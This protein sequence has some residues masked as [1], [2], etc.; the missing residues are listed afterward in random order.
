MARREPSESEESKSNDEVSSEDDQ[1]EKTD[2][3]GG[4]YE[5]KE[6]AVMPDYERQRLERMAANRAR[7]EALGL[8]TLASSLMSPA[9]QRSKSAQRKGKRKSVD[10]EDYEPDQD[11]ADADDDDDDLEQAQDIDDDDDGDFVARRSSSKPRKNKN[12]KGSKPRKGIASQKNVA[13]YVNE[14]EELMQA[15]TLS[16]QDSLPP[17]DKKPATAM[18]ET[19]GKTTKNQKFSSRVKMTEDDMIMHFFQF[20]GKFH[21]FASHSV[22]IATGFYTRKSISRNWNNDAE[23]GSGVITRK[24]LQQMATEHDFTWSDKELDDMMDCFDD[25]GDGKLNLADFRKVV[26]RCNMLQ[27][28]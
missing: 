6:Q 3:H 27:D 26:D 24:D 12:N 17:K 13:K 7:M 15:I 22:F 9:V 21:R 20:D 16:L 10:D 2:N 4:N 1:E 14:D 18:H 28:S 19:K 5:E 11:E 23:R 8:P 25:D